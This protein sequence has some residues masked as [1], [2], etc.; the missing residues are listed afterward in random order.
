MVTHSSILAWRLPWTEEPGGLRLL[1]PWGSP[2]KN[3]GEG[4]CA[5]LQGTFLTQ[6]GIEPESL[7]SPE[8]AG[9][10]YTTSTAWVA[11]GRCLMS[12]LQMAVWVAG[13]G[14]PLPCPAT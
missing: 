6:G 1:C 10:F 12:P 9:G 8:L 2:G 11:R 13:R 3:T 14:L 7:T 4:C 5:L